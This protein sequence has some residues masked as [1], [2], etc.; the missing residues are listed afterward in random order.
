MFKTLSIHPSPGEGPTPISVEIPPSRKT[1][2]GAHRL[3]IQRLKTFVKKM[4]MNGAITLMIVMTSCILASFPLIN[5]LGHFL[6]ELLQVK[7]LPRAALERVFPV[8]HDVSRR[9]VEKP[10]E[11]P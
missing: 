9:D 3:E 10:A 4:T 6:P 5:P 2:R 11:A 8:P 1:H 7:K